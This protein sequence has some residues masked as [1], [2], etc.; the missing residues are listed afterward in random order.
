MQSINYTYTIGWDLQN[1]LAVFECVAIRAYYYRNYPPTVFGYA[2]VKAR[3]ITD[4]LGAITRQD[5][6][7]IRAGTCS[8]LYLERHQLSNTCTWCWVEWRVRSLHSNVNFN[9]RS[10]DDENFLN[11]FVANYHALEC[12][13]LLLT[14]EP[15]NSYSAQFKIYVFVNQLKRQ[16]K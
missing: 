3:L 12:L 11:G 9:K 10:V 13:D 16:I 8:E 15:L 7:Q 5:N 2:V 4:L 6:A 14:K 1:C